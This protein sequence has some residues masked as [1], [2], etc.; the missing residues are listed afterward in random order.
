MY[1]RVFVILVLSVF[2]QSTSYAQTATPPFDSFASDGL[3]LLPSAESTALTS[4]VNLGVHSA[5]KIQPF[6]TPQTLQNYK[7]IF[8]S[9]AILAN[10]PMSEAEQQKLNLNIDKFLEKSKRVSISSLADAQSALYSA[11]SIRKD[12]GGSAI[13]EILVGV[14][15]WPE[16][17]QKKADGPVPALVKSTVWV[18]ISRRKLAWNSIST[19][20]RLSFER[21]EKD[22][23]SL[24]QGNINQLLLA[25]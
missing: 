12:E 13:L 3:G 10:F 5:T 25:F 16:V 18:S 23:I 17:K 11:V 22:I 8:N 21:I 24:Y 9:S 6:R 14:A 15:D 1:I 7:T 20:G 4:Q 19:D 2:F